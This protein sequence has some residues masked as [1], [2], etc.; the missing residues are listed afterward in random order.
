MTAL[1]PLR[2]EFLERYRPWS[3]KEILW[4]YERQLIGWPPVVELAVSKVVEGASSEAEIELAGLDKNDVFRVGELLRHLASGDSE[5]E[6]ARDKWLCASLSWAF[7]HRSQLPDPLGT[8]ES[9]FAD[10]D[11]PEQIRPF[12]RYLPAQDGYDPTKHSTS[13]NEKRLIAHWQAFVE[14]CGRKF[15][16][17]GAHQP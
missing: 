4:G 7:S 13:E 5:P 3:W 9:I 10:F 11:Y 8:V 17:G 12:V 1:P 15:E 6:N 16:I 2:Y 14:G